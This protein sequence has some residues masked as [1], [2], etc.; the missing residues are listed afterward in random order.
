MHF[1]RGAGPN[2]F[3]GFTFE[4]NA[5]DITSDGARGQRFY[6]TNFLGRRKS[7]EADPQP[8]PSR[9]KLQIGFAPRLKGKSCATC[10]FQGFRWQKACP[11]GHPLT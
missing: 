3:Y 6:G 4:D 5:T 2:T 1:E 7:S 8:G 11:K 10:G 9:G